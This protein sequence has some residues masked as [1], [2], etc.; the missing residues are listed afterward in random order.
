MVEKCRNHWWSR[1]SREFFIYAYS[2]DNDPERVIRLR[3]ELRVKMSRGKWAYGKRKRKTEKCLKTYKSEK[4]NCPLRNRWARPSCS[5]SL[6]IGPT[7][8]GHYGSLH[9]ALSGNYH[10]DA[11][12]L[13]GLFAHP[14]LCVSSPTKFAGHPHFWARPPIMLSVHPHSRVCPPTKFVAH[15]YCYV[16][17]PSKLSAHPHFWACPLTMLTAHP[18]SCVCPPT[19][20]AAHLHPCVRPLNKLSAHPHLFFLQPT[21]FAAPLPLVLMHWPT[22]LYTAIVELA[23]DQAFGTRSL[24]S[25]P[26]DQTCRNRQELQE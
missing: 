6:H 8:Q 22:F 17:A 26:T 24:F 16:W 4:T 7:V 12:L 15:R 18:H 5:A 1:V 21:K 23:H 11:L 20:F 13:T 10:Y 3:N 2:T 9:N 19:K 14:H 25:L